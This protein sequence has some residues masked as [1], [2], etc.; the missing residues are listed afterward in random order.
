MDVWMRPRDG[1]PLSAGTPADFDPYA[2]IARSTFFTTAGCIPAV[3]K[4]KPNARKARTV[5]GP[6]LWA[7]EDAGKGSFRRSGR[8]QRGAGP[9]LPPGPA[10]EE[11]LSSP[12]PRDGT[13]ESPATIIH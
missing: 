7:N 2:G 1:H 5:Y 4:R 3:S 12:P 6:G 9:L 10:R 13:S 11:R 8:A